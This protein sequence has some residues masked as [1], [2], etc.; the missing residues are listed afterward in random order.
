MSLNAALRLIS[1]VP[2]FQLMPVVV[3]L[4]DNLTNCA[5]LY[6]HELS[7]YCTLP[8]V[9]NHAASSWSFLRLFFCLSSCSHHLSWWASSSLSF[10]LSFAFNERIRVISWWNLASTC[11]W[12]R[13]KGRKVSLWGHSEEFVHMDG[14]DSSLEQAWVRAWWILSANLHKVY[15][16]QSRY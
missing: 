1:Q 15:V 4:R 2:S 6:D 3:Y 11:W 10:L 5:L 13:D 12:N 16:P 8:L 9:H 7:A 14:R